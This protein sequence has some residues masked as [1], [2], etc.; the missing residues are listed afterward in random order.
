VRTGSA[1]HCWGKE[2]GERMKE[3]K[4]GGRKEEGGSNSDKI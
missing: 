4:E 2:E 1:V 3:E